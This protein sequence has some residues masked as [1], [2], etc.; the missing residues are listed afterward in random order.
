MTFGEFQAMVEGYKWRSEQ[1]D[2]RVARFVAP[3]INACH[4]VKLK[5][6]ITIETL[7]GYD[8]V[9]R[10]REIENGKKTG[11]QLKAELAELIGEIGAGR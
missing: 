10:Y 1:D 11:K 7:L 4:S 9:K 5:R 6:P 8:P 2:I 3:I